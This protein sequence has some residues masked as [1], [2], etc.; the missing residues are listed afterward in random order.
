MSYRLEDSGTVSR[1]DSDVPVLN[2]GRAELSRD[3]DT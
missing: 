2:A 1:G 3:S